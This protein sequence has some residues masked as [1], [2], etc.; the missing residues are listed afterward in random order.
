MT[1]KIIIGVVSV[2]FL[3]V[4]GCFIGINWKG[5]KTLMSGAQIYTKSQM[6][7]SYNQGYEDANT[8][9]KNY[10]AQIEYYKGIVEDNKL[11]IQNLNN[12]IT[13]LKNSNETYRKQ[14]THLQS[15][16]ADNQQTINN[17]QDLIKTN[18][19]AI[20]E[21]ETQI[22]NYETQV[23]NLQK[24]IAYYEEYISSLEND[25]QVVATFEYDGSVYNLQVLNKGSYASVVSPT[26]TE[27]VVFNGWTVDGQI[28]DLNTYAVT[29]N[30]KFVAD[31][32]YKYDVNFI[33][34]GETANSEIVSLNSSATLPTVPAKDGYEFDG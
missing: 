22:S 1:K 9:E 5:L 14:I 18:D 2:L 23:A 25:T 10:L 17:L 30:T 19:I 26:S 4:V 8:N 20:Y 31:L 29:K 6:E 16:N 21:L 7:E 32:S 33:V 11:Q 13:I 3:T 24:S 34:D 12:S 27:Y 28:V 15:T